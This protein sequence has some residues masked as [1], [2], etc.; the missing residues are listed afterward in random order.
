MLHKEKTFQLPAAIYKSSSL[1]RFFLFFK[2]DLSFPKYY[3]ISQLSNNG[4]R[5][6]KMSKT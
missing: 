4:N 3:K 6:I 5:D 2:Y 1:F